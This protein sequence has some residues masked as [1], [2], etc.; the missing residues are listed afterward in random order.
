MRLTASTWNPI[1]QPLARLAS[2][3]LVI[4]S[5]H[6][7]RV[8]PR[9]IPGKMNIKADYLSRSENGIIPSYDCVIAQCSQLP[10]CLVC[11]L[12]RKLLSSLARLISFGLT[13]GTSVSL[14]SGL[15]TLKYATLH[16]GSGAKDMISSL[17]D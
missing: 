16:V 5:K 14:A 7:T 8:Q 3:L 11:L 15:L 1:L 2:A 12:P 10:T 4:A 17:Q 9:H 6:L 13:E